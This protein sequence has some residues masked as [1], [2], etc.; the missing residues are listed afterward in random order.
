MKDAGF[1]MTSN[2]G[3]SYRRFTHADDRFILVHAPHP[4]KAFRPDLLRVIKH[5]LESKLGW[6]EDI[7]EIKPK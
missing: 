7:F 6:D 2:A 1:A 5:K 4:D 3:G